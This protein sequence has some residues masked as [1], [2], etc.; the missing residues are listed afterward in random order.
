MSVLTLSS[1]LRCVCVCVCPGT[2]YVCALTLAVMGLKM[3][4]ALMEHLEA[5]KQAGKLP[6]VLVTDG[7]TSVGAMHV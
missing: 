4:K 3:G 7:L 1:F 2:I 6:D 5:A